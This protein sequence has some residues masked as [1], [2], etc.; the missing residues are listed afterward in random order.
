MIF[1]VIACNRCTTHW[2]TEQRHSEHPDSTVECPGCG[3]QHSGRQRTL[4]TASTREAACEARG[5]LLANKAGHGDEYRTNPAY[6]DAE[7]QVRDTLPIDRDAFE[8]AVNDT[9]G[10]HRQILEDAVDAHPVGK[11]AF[12]DAVDTHPVGKHAF[13]DEAADALAKP[14]GNEP[15]PYGSTDTDNKTFPRPLYPAEQVKQNTTTISEIN[16][17]QIYSNAGLTITQQRTHKAT[18]TVSAHQPITG[19]WHELVTQPVVKKHFLNAVRTVTNR[20]YDELETVLNA[21]EILETPGNGHG[22]RSLFHSIRKRNSEHATKELLRVI[23]ELGIGHS[24]VNDIH[25]TARLFRFADPERDNAR[26]PTLVVE[27]NHDELRNMPRSQR[28]DVCELLGTLSKAFDIRL[29]CT[30]VTESYLRHYYRE[31]L[32]GVSEWEKTHRVESQVDEALTNL[33]V[34]STHVQILRALNDQPGETLSYHEVYANL[35]ISRSRVRQCISTLKNYGLVEP[36]GSDSAKKLSLLDAGR[37]VLT[38]MNEHHGQQITLENSVSGT[39]KSQRQRRVTR[40]TPDGHRTGTDCHNFSTAP[41]TAGTYRTAWLNRADHA[42]ITACGV[43]RGTVTV[44]NDSVDG[45]DGDTRFVSFDEERG[46]AVVS[47]HATNPLDYTTSLAV[48]LASPDFVDAALDEM[49]IEAVIDEVPAEIL[50]NAR[51][52]GYLTEEVLGDA[53]EFRDMLVSW[54]EDIEK[55]TR[56]LRHKK[57]D[58]RDEFLSEI[59]RESHGLAGSVVHLLDSAGTDLVRDIRVPGQTNSGKLES[60]AESMAHSVFIQS[61]YQAQVAYRELFE[62]REKKRA[63]KISVEVDAADPFGSLIGSFVVRGKGAERVTDALEETLNGCEPHEDAAEFS[64]PVPFRVVSREMVAATAARVLSS[65]NLRVTRDIVSILHGVVDSPFSV[66]EALQQLAPEPEVREM[67]AVEL[68]YALQ[69]LTADDVFSEFTPNVA[70]IVMVLVDA[71]CVLSQ[72]ELAERAGVSTQTVRNH[73]DVLEAMGVVRRGP[74]G[75]GWRFAV[76]FRSERGDGVM[77]TTCSQS[78]DAVVEAVVKAVG[79]G[80][81]CGVMCGEVV[82]GGRLAGGC[83]TGRWCVVATK[84]SGGGDVPSEEREVMIGEEPSQTPITASDSD[85]DG[86]SDGSDSDDEHE[87]DSRA[88]ESSNDN[89]PVIDTDFSDVSIAGSVCGD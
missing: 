47:V 30:R 72:S 6:E 82:R 49:T 24:T 15:E 81:S 63:S 62:E 46:E 2:V 84:L 66:A 87:L 12:E 50:R 43:D 41:P 55:K 17:T 27:V 16:D 80:F 38:H 83:V 14:L 11:H 67:D 85:G 45:V 7:Q 89:D 54:G 68:R 48:A 39:P 57:Y 32:P 76:S 28:I 13:E 53:S 33:D 44:V 74:G 34:D 75:S 61:R 25:A 51:Q 88:G 29:E 78:V 58:D 71:D 79:E 23:R 10:E 65:K 18:A 9:I 35:E 8:N 21:A 19:L 69:Q 56:M 64:V 52:I 59:L 5:Q 4:A 3:K 70:E 60:L 86:D 37:E 36:F 22:T 73:A 20:G 77:P 1:A 40:D 31:H 42:A 26:A